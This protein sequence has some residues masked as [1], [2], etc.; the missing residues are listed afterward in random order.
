MVEVEMSTKEDSHPKEQQNIE[1]ENNNDGNLWVNINES[2][3][4]NQSKLLQIVKDLKQELQS[5]KEDNE[6]I[7]KSQEE[8]NNVLLTKIH[9]KEI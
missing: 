1:G 6:L 7:L 9:E 5:V 3:N 4:D 2:R 8:L